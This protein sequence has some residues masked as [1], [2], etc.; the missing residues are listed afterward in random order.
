[1]SWAKI[2]ALPRMPIPYGRQTIEDD[3]VAAV[4]RTLRGDWLTQGPAVRAFEEAVATACDAPYAVAYSSGTAALHGAALAAGAGPGDELLTSAITFAASANC[5]AYVG[6]TPVFAD[7]DPQTWN[8]SAESVRAALTPRTRIVVPV[9]FSGLPAPIAEIRAAVGPDVV[10]VEDAAHAI[11]ARQADEPVGSCRHSDMAIFSFHPVKTITSGEGGVVT[12]RDARLY[13][14]LLET[15]THGMTKDAGRLEHPDE[16]GW[17]ME[18]Q[19]LGF[20]YRIT[21]LQAALGVSQMAKLERFVE[22]RN[23][24]AAR[25]DELLGDLA[26]L[27]LAPAT[28]AGSR[29]GRHLYVVHHRDGADARRRLYDGLRE[30]EIFAQV[31]YLPVYRHPW[32]RATYGY[33]AGLCPHAEDYYAGCLSLPCF[34][35]LTEAEQDTVVAAVRELA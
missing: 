6:A 12:T 8:V 2:L 7:I 25:Y 3:D 33:E 13:E 9:H 32:Y 15:R 18:Q 11:G 5:G 20:N 30:R 34:P 22:R 10:I 31:H 35:A 29:H 28:P 21:D 1:M 14:R 16:G 26:T 19:S 17:Y 27:R 4:T 23:A 24:I